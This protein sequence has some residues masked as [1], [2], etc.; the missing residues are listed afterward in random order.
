[1]RLPIRKE[2]G[3]LK[4]Y[5]LDRQYA[6]IKL[7]QNESPVDVPEVIKKKVLKRL[8]GADWNRYPTPF[9]DP[10]RARIAA[11]EGWMPEGVVVTGGSNILIQALLLTTALG[12]KVMTVSPS[13][14]LY[15]IEGLLLGNRVVEVPLDKRDFSLPVSLFIRTLKNNRPK[16]V[17]LANPNAP[18]GNLFAEEDLLAIVAAAEKVGAIVAVDEAYYPFS[19]MTMA[20]HLKNCPNLVVIRTLSKAFSL[21][22]V[23]LGYLLGAPALVGELL[24]VV[25]PFSVGIL[26]QIVGEAVLE[27]RGYVAQRVNEVIAERELIYQGLR[28]IPGLKVY[29]SHANYVLFQTPQS[30]R[31]FEGLM[32]SDILIRDVSGKNLPHALR[33]SVGTKE[34]NRKFLEAM[35]QLSR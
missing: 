35:S 24:K 21:G 9:C 22:G 13:F 34:E 16:V 10:L 18:T 6:R 5:R 7:N 28:E 2:L 32:K 12:A 1:M 8:G 23:R 19:G 3:K 11:L 20:G 26:S 29:P 30:D 25:L 14:S 31:L 4:G 27:E 17:F 33:V 15:A